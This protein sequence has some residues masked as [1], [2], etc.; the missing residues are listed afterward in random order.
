MRAALVIA[1]NDLRRLLRERSAL[2]W[3]F[4]GPL[5]FTGFFGTLFRAQPERATTVSLVDHD[6]GG[7]VARVLTLILA[8]DKIEVKPASAVAGDRFVLEVPEGAALAL[9]AG[10]PVKLVLHTPDEGET[11]LERRVRFKIEKALL[12]TFLLANPGDVPADT[13]AEVLRRRLAENRSISV[14]RADI[15][16][17]R[18]DITA[19]FQRAVP[20]YLVLFIFLNLLVS[21]AGLAEERASGRLRRLFIAPL[22]KAEIV[23]GK[24][25]T[26]VAVGWVQTAWM[27]GTG[28]LLFKIR[29]ADHGWVLFAFLTLYALASGSLGMLLGTLFKD[30][31]KCRSM[32]IWG[33]VLLS[34]LGG[35]WW[36]LELVGPTM[37]TIGHLVPTGW[38]M[39]SVNA[40][41]AY[42]AGAKEVAPYALA[43]VGLTVVSLTL[44]VR[45][46]R[47]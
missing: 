11:N 28:V 37:R 6:A 2:F 7:Y 9:A 25:L 14:R 41:L 43:F 44:A 33:A 40:M 10:K 20:S 8:Q 21:G 16:V 34:P 35:L 26:R 42:G 39:E 31:D 17:Q 29:W 3:I 19:G 15:G 47:P 38:A 24:L 23:A 27:L 36:P 4:V 22:S 45:R 5:L 32:A 30:P 13:D 1:L 12:S 18:R 46:L